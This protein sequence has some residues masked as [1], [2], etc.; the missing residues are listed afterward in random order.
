MA[1][2][3]YYVV[4]HRSQWRIKFEDQD[5]GPYMT[6]RDAVVAAVTAAHRVGQHGHDARVLVQEGESHYRTEWIYGCDPYPP[7]DR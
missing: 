2:A 1:R 6:Q 4:R 7:H 3:H 5:F